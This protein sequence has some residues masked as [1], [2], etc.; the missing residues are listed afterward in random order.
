MTDQ[1]SKHEA[2]AI[3]K[4][5]KIEIGPDETRS[6]TEVAVAATLGSLGLNIDK[7]DESR[8]TVVKPD[9]AESEIPIL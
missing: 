7:S 9:Q 5:L 4:N 2:L 1:I 8:R 3:I 6:I